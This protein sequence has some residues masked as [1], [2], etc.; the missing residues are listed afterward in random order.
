MC[1]SAEPRDQVFVKGYGFL[2][3]AKNIVEKIGKNIS[4]SSSVKYIQ[5][6]LDHA[7]PSATVEFKTN[8]KKV[9][10]KTAEATSDL[11]SNK[12][13]NRMKNI[14]R[15]SP[16]NDSETITNEHHKEIPKEK[17]I[18]PEEKQKIIDD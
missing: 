3:F 12:V 17:Y 2:S 5:K 1:C 6:F 16:E 13:A 10:Q 7:K 18:Y 9:I 11:I 15:S 4:K 14:F 8:S